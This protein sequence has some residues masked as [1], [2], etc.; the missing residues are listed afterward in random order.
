MPT[1]VRESAKFSLTQTAG[2]PSYNFY[3]GKIVVN[4]NPNFGTIIDQ[5]KELQTITNYSPDL[6]RIFELYSEIPLIKNEMNELKEL[7]VQYHK[8]NSPSTIGKIVDTGSKMAS[9]VQAYPQI[10]TIVSDVLNA[11]TISIPSCNFPGLC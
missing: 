4:G 1:S 11:I 3:I 7:M 2:L 9:I 6:A 8:H 10:K 5:S